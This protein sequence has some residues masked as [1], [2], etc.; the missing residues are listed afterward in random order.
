MEE[1][2]NRDD[3]GRFAKGHDS[4]VYERKPGANPGGRPR[5]P[6]RQV[7]DALDKAE[8][9]MP[10]IIDG[11][12]Q[13]AKGLLVCPHCQKG[14]LGAGGDQRAGEYLVDRRLGKPRQAHDIGVGE[15]QIQAAT[16]LLE[17]LNANRKR[18]SEA[19]EG[20]SEEGTG[21]PES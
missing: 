14:I 12:I 21:Q 20:Q 2:N 13:R 10:D 17:S 18:R 1:N 5:E 19:D 3:K 15:D 9:A 16:R 6:K 7:Q 11:M 4:T 8:E